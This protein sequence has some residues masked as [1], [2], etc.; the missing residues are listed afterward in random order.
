METINKILI[1]QSQQKHIITT[2]RN[3][4]KIIFQVL[5]ESSYDTKEVKCLLLD[6]GDRYKKI[7]LEVDRLISKQLPDRVDI[8]Y[9]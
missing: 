8:N 2:K 5:K 4:M 3:Y 7:N 6:I 9:Y 1:N